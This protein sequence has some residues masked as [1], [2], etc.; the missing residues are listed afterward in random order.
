MKK[1][2]PIIL[3]GILLIIG[4]YL[5][6]NLLNN[7]QEKENL[8]EALNAE[9]VT[10]KDKDGQNHAKIQV[11]ETQKVKDFL[12]IKSKDS[13]VMKLQAL[14]KQYKG[15]LDE[16]S[17][18]TVVTTETVVSTSSSTEVVFTQPIKNS[19]NI[20]YPTYKSSFNLKGWITG[21]TVANKDSTL[22]DLKVR[23]EY[24][25]IVG[26]EKQGLFKPSK[27]FVEVTNKNPYTETTS[28]RTYQ[29]SIKPEKK[30]AIGPFGGIN[31]TGRPIFGV[32]VTYSLISF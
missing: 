8:I 26:R 15:K 14:V 31:F 17:S 19:T 24:S 13:T 29:V 6:D 21:T 11:L 28:L 2:I 20:V 23:N 3:M 10:W 4:S 7:F 32:G 5:Y 1:Y 16:G 18:A 27:P 12:S 9:L 25:V 30:W 22:L